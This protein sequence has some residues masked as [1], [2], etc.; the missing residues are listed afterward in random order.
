MRR[1][2]NYVVMPAFVVAGAILSA[3]LLMPIVD[4]ILPREPNEGVFVGGLV[5]AIGAIIA[6]KVYRRIEKAVLRRNQQQLGDTTK[7]NS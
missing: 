4:A 3:V 6:L 2:C 5:A 1:L 7:P